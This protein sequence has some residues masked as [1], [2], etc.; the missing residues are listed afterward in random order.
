ME[1]FERIHVCTTLNVEESFVIYCLDILCPC[2]ISFI[3]NHLRHGIESKTVEAHLNLQDYWDLVKQ[4]K[5]KPVFIFEII[6]IKVQMLC[7]C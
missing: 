4:F 1:E 7:E 2:D 5:K 6:F 3:T